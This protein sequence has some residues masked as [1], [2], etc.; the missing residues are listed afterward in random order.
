MSLPFLPILPAE[1][2]VVVVVV[3]VQSNLSF[4]LSSPSVLTLSVSTS[5]EAP[6]LFE[7]VSRVVY[8][9]TGKLG[10]EVVCQTVSGQSKCWTVFFV[11]Y[12]ISSSSLRLSLLVPCRERENPRNS[13]GETKE[14]DE[15][16][17]L[18]VPAS[19]E[20]FF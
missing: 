12:A 9:P 16:R 3:S 20:L 18:E 7:F 2:V 6:R 5:I 15:L 1:R 14:S 19:K 4:P 8:N 11:C 13:V 10:A 17:E